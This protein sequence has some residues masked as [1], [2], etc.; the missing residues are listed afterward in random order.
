MGRVISGEY[1]MGRRLLTG[2]SDPSGLDLTF[3]LDGS[4]VF[5]GID[6]DKSVVGRGHVVPPGFVQAVC[7][8]LSH[9][10]LAALKKR[11][12]VTRESRL[13]FL[14]PVYAGDRF[15]A[16]GTVVSDGGAGGVVAVQARLFNSKGQL[17][18]EGDIEVFILGAD[19][20]RKMT[21][22]GMVPLELKRFFA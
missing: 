10:S 20:V 4:R 15:R 9:A 3:E 14:K 2:S 22:D 21:K 7:D 11:I 5:C 17:C 6:A 1:L 12:G 13:R 18:V 19:Q 8:D 16:D